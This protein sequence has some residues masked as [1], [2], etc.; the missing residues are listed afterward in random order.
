MRRRRQTRLTAIGAADR[1]SLTVG[2]GKTAWQHAHT[3]WSGLESIRRSHNA[4]FDDVTCGGDS[5]NR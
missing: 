1:L 4:A 3:N 5:A 2:I